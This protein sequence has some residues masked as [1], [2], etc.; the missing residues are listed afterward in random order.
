MTESSNNITN[1]NCEKDNIDSDYIRI[2]G[3]SKHIQYMENARKRKP[4]KKDYKELQSILRD[5]GIHISL[6]D[7]PE[8][9]SISELEF[10]KKSKIKEKLNSTDSSD[11]SNKPMFSLT[12]IKNNKKTEEE[13]VNIHKKE[14][15]WTKI[16]IP[17]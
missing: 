2:L 8:F 14:L 10:W 17:F 16:N 1:Q 15:D 13:K 11:K 12:K 9:N 4:D 5:F 7:L 6:D 3:K